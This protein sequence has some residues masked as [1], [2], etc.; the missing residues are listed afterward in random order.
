ME[1]GVLKMEV[2]GRY[3]EGKIPGEGEERDPEP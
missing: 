3:A 1:V 2:R